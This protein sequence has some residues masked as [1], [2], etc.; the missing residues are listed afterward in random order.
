M[1]ALLGLSLAALAGGVGL[2]AWSVAIGR[3]S[4]VL[5]IVFPV[6]SSSSLGFL[7]GVVLLVVGFLTLPFGLANEWEGGAPVPEVAESATSTPGSGVGGFVLVGPVPILFGSW[8][9]ISRRS[10]W[11]LALAGAVLFTAAIVAVVW[12]AR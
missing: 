11:W 10:R 9:G 4:V 2:I 3:A 7:L 6:V 8:K 1:R 5:V 12:L